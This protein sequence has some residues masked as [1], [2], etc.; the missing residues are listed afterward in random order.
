MHSPTAICPRRLP[1]IR[2]PVQ[3]TASRAIRQSPPTRARPQDGL[4]IRPLMRPHGARRLQELQALS[5]RVCLLI[6]RLLLASAPP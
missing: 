4:S 1:I 3:T 2:N 6:S 5:I